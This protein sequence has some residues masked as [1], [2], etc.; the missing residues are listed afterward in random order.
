[1]E[2]VIVVSSGGTG[3][4][5]ATARRFTRQRARVVIVGRR[6]DVLARAAGQIGDAYPDAAA[7]AS[8]DCSS[9][10][11]TMQGRTMKTI[12]LIGG[13]NWE[14]S[15]EYYRLVNQHMKARLGGRRNACSIMATVCFDEIKTLQHAGEWD[16]LGRLMQQAARPA[17]KA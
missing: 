17:R 8:P 2:Q 15:A 6:A 7:A 14:S 16:E 10:S 5:L 11:R 9:T 4:G 1:M 12:G 3:I 13:M